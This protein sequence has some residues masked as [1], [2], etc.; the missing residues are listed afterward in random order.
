[1]RIW[2]ALGLLGTTVACSSDGGGF[3]DDCAKSDN[4]CNGSV[5]ESC[6]E[7]GT[8]AGVNRWFRYTRDCAETD[9]VCVMLGG[10]AECAVSE[11]A[12]AC[13]EDEIGERTCGPD[14]DRVILCAERIDGRGT[15]TQVDDV[16]EEGESCVPRS[17]FSANCELD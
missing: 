10:Y 15:V 16:C 13:P 9:Q 3:L 5:A 1:M 14:G 12:P 4:R 2:L 11:D 17:E 7:A 8:K 6:E